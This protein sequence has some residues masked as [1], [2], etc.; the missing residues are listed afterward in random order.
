MAVIRR[1]ADGD[2][3]QVVEIWYCSWAHTFPNLQHPQPIEQWK[4]RFQAEYIHQAE[5]WVAVRLDRIV[6]FV[7]VCDGA[8]AQLF[9][10]TDFQRDGIGSA[11]MNQAKRISPRSLKLTTLQQNQQARQ[12]YEKHNFVAGA[13]GIN[14]RNGQPNIEYFW[15]P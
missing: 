4:L 3:D 10:D 8:I 7:V 2:L 5:T 1:F 15:N 13:S 9:V 6:G 12:F 11:L 14:P